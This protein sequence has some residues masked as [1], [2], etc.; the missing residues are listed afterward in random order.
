[1][2]AI[3]VRTD[4]RLQHTLSPKLQQAVR[5]LQLSSLDFAQE[6]HDVVGNNPFL[7]LDEAELEA[8]VAPDGE[9]EPNAGAAQGAKDESASATDTGLAGDSDRD[10]W[11]ADGLSSSQRSGNVELSALDLVAIESSLAGHLHAQLA[12]LALPQRGQLLAKV[13]IE[14]LDDDGY[15]R[16]TL[17]ELLAITDLR[18]PATTAEMERALECVQSLEPAGVGARSVAECLLLQLPLI[19]CEETRAV[20]QRIV[21]QHLQCLAARDIAELALA[22]GRSA[23]EIEPVCA[24]IR[25][26]DPHPGWRFGSTQVQYVIPDV[27]VRKVRGAWSVKL[28]PAIVPKVKMNQVYA[29]M[30]QR[31]K[32]EPNSEL[33]GH[34]QDARW[35]LRN[36]EQRFSTILGVAQAIVRRQRHFLDFGE[37]AMK[38]LGLREIADELGLHEST[39]S[40]V[41][42]NKYLATPLG[43][44]EL[45]HFF[46][47]AMVTASGAAC[48]G[49]AIRG[50]VKAMIEAEPRD[51]PLSDAELT[52]QL[53]SQ[54]LTVARRTVTK[55]RQLLHIE[56]FEH[57][58][59]LK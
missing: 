10:V 4:H 46:S 1:M 31:C 58:R 12:V 50:L 28:N 37:M 53:A 29:E 38:P 9:A 23:A 47:R 59:R 11:Q 33:A 19:E 6:L 15:L 27:I 43:V 39:V 49:T 22:L 45:K 40:R 18:P 52:R 48:S 24:R 26:L 21:T 54:G 42:N 34:L 56:S 13:I 30:F 32:R 5:L 36:V 25:Q 55:Y 20:A 16:T 44:F 35:T 3:E 8:D 57:R 14:S 2:A 41:T 51:Q 7:D 17:D